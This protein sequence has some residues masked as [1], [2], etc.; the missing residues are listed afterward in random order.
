MTESVYNGAN[1]PFQ[2]FVVRLV[3]AISMQKLDTQYAGLADSYYLA[4]IGY[5]EDVVRPKDLKTL[6]C[7]ILVGQYSLLTPTRTAVYYVIGLATKIC[8]QLGF[9]DEKT[10][11]LGADDALTLDM[12]RRVSWSIRTM[13]YGLS[14]AMGRP[15]GF[16]KTD[17]D[18][19]V[20]YFDTAKDIN[21]AK[22]GIIQGPPDVKKLVAIHF[23]KMRELQA[24]IRRVLYK[25]KANGPRDDGHPWFLEFEGRMNMW[26]EAS[27][28]DPAWCKP[29]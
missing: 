10:I 7:L 27:P 11:A 19:D 16:S 3:M 4:A 9:A 29:W 18:V 24:E 8:Q 20:G 22:D 2:N 28:T 15:C 21:I 12:R 23:C 14:Q 5:F 25:K 1:D 6:Q 17:D 13:E 26:L